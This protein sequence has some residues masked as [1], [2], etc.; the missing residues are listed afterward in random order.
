MTSQIA[1]TLHAHLLRD[2]GQEDLTFAIWR[3]SSGQHRRSAILTDILLPEISDRQ[4]HGNA[5]FNPEYLLRAAK[6]A[7]AGGGGLAFLHS[8][9]GGS[10]WQAMSEPDRQAE[11]RVSRLAMATTGHPLVGMTL[12]GRDSS[13]SARV[14][15]RSGST[16]TAE[17]SDCNSVRVVGSHLGVTFNPRL[18]PTPEN[19]ATLTRTVS[20][21]GDR[22]QANIARLRVL[23]VGAGSVG[24]PIIEALARTGIMQ[25]TVIDPDRVE[26]LNLDRLYG[27]TRLDA[28][29][30][31]PKHRIAR[32][33]LRRAATASTPQHR[34]LDLS[35]CTT[36]GLDLALDHDIIF[37]C[38][39]RPWPRHVLNVIA[40]HDLIPVV[41]G[42]VAIKTMPGGG[43]RNAY[44]QTTVARPDGACLA[45]AGQ[46]TLSDVQ[47]DRDGS[48]Q[49]GSYLETLSRDHPL[50]A[51]QNVAAVSFSAAGAQLGHFLSFVVNPS[52]LGDPGIVR[53][54]LAR[55]S[56]D[57]TA[58]QC[59]DGCAFAASVG[60][61]DGRLD[62]TGPD[63]APARA[64]T[65]STHTVAALIRLARRRARMRA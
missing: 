23:V 31:R 62:P 50:R 33:V 19:E 6:A 24:M 27:A 14:W 4:V 48:L 28:I 44:W 2:D 38:V 10:G 61:G 11:Q 59:R 8:H 3:P 37:C 5:S 55:H 63:H 7:A 9:P 20:A 34:T 52:G 54:D 21:W 60:L 36:N 41:D 49:A 65:W 47:L 12:A 43:L 42:G 15:D 46:Y 35:A 29:L 53:H 13:W 17:A 39:D 32:R 22:T 1:D 40:Y 30:Q 58:G 57:R 51:R 25:I 16:R 26:L 18:S 45:C 64:S 56:S